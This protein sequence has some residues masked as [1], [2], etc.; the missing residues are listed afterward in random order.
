M[1][2]YR[3]DRDVLGSWRLSWLVSDGP[4]IDYRRILRVQKGYII[5][6]SRWE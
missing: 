1:L 2:E 4:S 6:V 3:I 5:P